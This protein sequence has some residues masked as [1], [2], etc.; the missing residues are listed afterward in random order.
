MNIDLTGKRALVCGSTQGL[1]KA[2]A[3][4]LANLGAT[5]MLMAR[6]ESSLRQTQLE[7]D[8]GS[9]QSHEYIVADFSNVQQVTERIRGYAESRPPIH[10]LV[11]NTG[12]P[13]GGQI[14]DADPQEF[15]AAFSAH[16]VCN[17][18]LAQ[19]LIPGMKAERYGRIINIVSTSVRQPID[20]LGV[21]NTTRG[22]V[23]S[24][25]KT[26][27]KELAPFGITVNNVLPGSTK[28]ARIYFL[29]KS[30]AEKTGRTIEDVTNE[31]LGEIPMGRFAEPEEFAA[32]VAF[33]ASPAASYVTG[34]SF[35][36][37]G[38]K[39]RSL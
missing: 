10:I 27:S 14:V 4:E 13:P 11:N 5:I 29:I 17:H 32:A 1:G 30:K 9:G 15:V 25:A 21:S 36:V 19:A 12:G 23:A 34:V 39:I 22:A 38:G 26:L 24:W 7:L 35:P 28:T 37:D 2:S 6:N 3:I 18:V 20:G 31:M 33:L 8:R 16:I